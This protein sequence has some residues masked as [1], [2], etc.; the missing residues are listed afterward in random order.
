MDV[1]PT[2]GR[3]GRRALWWRLPLGAL[4]PEYAEVLGTAIPEGAVGATP[5][6]CFG[7]PCHVVDYG[8]IRA[9]MCVPP[10]YAMAV[11][12]FT[13][14]VRVATVARAEPALA[15]SVPFPPGI[16]GV[17]EGARN[18]AV[19]KEGMSPWVYG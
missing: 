6:V 3:S 7:C 11:G 15:S 17:L 19:Q 9:S 5:A 10:H 4:T 14:T 16:R 12:I 13:H 18:E 1:S 8:D 2:S